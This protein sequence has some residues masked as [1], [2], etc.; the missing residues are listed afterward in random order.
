MAKFGFDKAA[1]A[2]RDAIQER[3]TAAHNELTDAIAGFELALEPLVTAVNAKVDA[4]NEALQDA[5]G[6]LED[7]ANSAQ[8]AFDEK[9]ERWQESDK[10]QAVFEWMSELTYEAL[11]GSIADVSHLSV[12]NITHEMGVMD[13][14]YDLSE[15]VTEEPSY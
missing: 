14:A 8:E 3:L 11:S 9:S 13:D 15:H 2:R 12:D 1:R 10:G 4:Y 6:F 7:E 5:R